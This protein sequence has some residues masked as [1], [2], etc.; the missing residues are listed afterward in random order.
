MS[1]IKDYGKTLE[2][3]MDVNRIDKALGVIGVSLTDQN[4]ELRNLDDVLID[5]GKKWTGLDKNQKAYITTALAGTRQQTRL[6]AVF[7][8]FDRT[9]ELSKISSDSLGAS[10]AQQAKYLNSIEYAVNMMQTAWQ[11]FITNVV[12]SDI[13]IFFTNLLTVSIKFFRRNSK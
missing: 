8:N 7:E 12:D 11:D 1:E 6:L 4:N 9:M 10:Y 13:V 2:D 5:V 3:G